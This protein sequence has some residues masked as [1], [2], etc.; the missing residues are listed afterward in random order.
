[1]KAEQ[2]IKFIAKK[3]A[4]KLQ[5]SFLENNTVIN[6]VAAVNVRR[7]FYFAVVAML[8]NIISMFIFGKDISSGD[9]IEN[10]WHMEIVIC[11]LI[12][13]VIM[14]VLASISFILKKNKKENSALCMFQY[15]TI[16]VPLIFGTV[17]VYVDQA[18]TTNITPIL[19]ACCI[20]G[21]VFLIRPFIAVI[22]YVTTAFV[23]FYILGLAQMNQAVLLSNRING[24]A[25][26][27]VG[28]CLSLIFWKASV[29]NILQKRHIIKQQFELTQ[30]NQELELLAFHDSMTCLYSRR[31][32]E[33]LL[34]NEIT[35]LYLSGH[36]SCII[37]MD[38]DNFKNINDN[39]GHPAGD[40]VIKRVASILLENVRDSDYIA[41]WGGDEFLILLPHASLSRGRLV[42]E[43][44]R[45]IIENE[46]L[47][48]NGIE[49][50]LTSSFGIT[51]ISGDKNDSLKRAYA[52]ADKALYLAK[53]KGK[54][55]IEVVS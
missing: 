7:T 24:I 25:C 52:N 51:N 44:L 10:K 50:Q 47:F 13:F 9:E 53:E 54:N 37:I 12:I 11:H 22:T 23:F 6:D 21:G 38:I 36:E 35:R 27:G 40:M 41:R 28:F 4:N 39:Y 29:S 30:K 16:A 14:A 18:V 1:M 33:E 46:T 26:I 20:T 19:I 8:V 15:V 48:F 42:A 5:Y 17:F 45:K 34:E 31:K 43:K 3:I 32:L 49:T 2:L 55:C